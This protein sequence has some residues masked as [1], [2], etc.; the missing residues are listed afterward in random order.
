MKPNFICIGAQKGGT[1]SLKNYLNFHPEIYMANKEKH[2]FDRALSKGEL[3]N[4][5]IKKYNQSFKTTKTIVGEK[6]P[7]YCY[8]RYAIDRIYDYDKN[9]KLIIILREPISRGFSQYNMNLTA[10]KGKTLMDV[11]EEKILNDF[12]KKYIKLHEL[13]SNGANYITRGFYDEILEYILSKFPKN[14]IYV[15]IS[16]EINKNKLKYYNEIYDFLGATKLKKINKTLN[17]HIRKYDKD[18]PKKL[19]KYLYNIYKPHNEKLYEIL[20]RKIDI[21]EDYYIQLEKAF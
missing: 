21:W 14:N 15:G 5:D 13:K 2:F 17:A 19:E 4:K 8:L 1:T 16:E 9:M 20:G 6:T 3:S 12:K 18:I 7:S 10:K 11:T